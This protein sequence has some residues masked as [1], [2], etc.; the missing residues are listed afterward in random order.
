MKTDRIPKA[1][2]V[3]FKNA[4]YRGRQ[5]QNLRR[6]IAIHQNWVFYSDGSNKNDA[7]TVD[8]FQEWAVHAHELVRETCE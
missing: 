8:A 5:V 7:C 6:I 2:E 4:S 1:G 3:Y